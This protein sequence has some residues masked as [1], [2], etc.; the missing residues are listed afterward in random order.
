[1]D[2][3]LVT[4]ADAGPGLAIARRLIGMGCRVYALATQFP[5]NPFPHDNFIT[6]ACNL[7]DPEAL[8]KVAE[9]IVARDGHITYVVHAARQPVAPLLDSPVATLVE[10]INVGLLAPLALARV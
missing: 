6:L 7:A 3:A 10:R 4:G 8:T 5:R 2:I 9:D 1:M